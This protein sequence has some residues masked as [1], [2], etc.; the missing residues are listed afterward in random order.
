MRPV[1]RALQNAGVIEG[2]YEGYPGKVIGQYYRVTSVGR[3]ALA[4]HEEGGQRA[5]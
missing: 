2:K 4:S 1:V 5:V 3:E